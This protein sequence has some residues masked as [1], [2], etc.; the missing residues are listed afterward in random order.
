VHNKDTRVQC[1]TPGEG[2][3]QPPR[4][5]PTVQQP[6]CMAHAMV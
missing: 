4:Q 6:A 1:R 5:A 2:H 3:A